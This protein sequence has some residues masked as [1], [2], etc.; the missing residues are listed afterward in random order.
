MTGKYRYP[1]TSTPDGWYHV[2]AS[3]E[4]EVGQV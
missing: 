3:E 2:A 4:V 1:F